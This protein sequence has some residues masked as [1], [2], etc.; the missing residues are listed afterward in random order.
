MSEKTLKKI[1]GWCEFTGVD[2]EGKI[3]CWVSGDDKFKIVKRKNY[4]KKFE[5]RESELPLFDKFLRKEKI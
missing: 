1:C 5:P 3:S 4:C 2:G